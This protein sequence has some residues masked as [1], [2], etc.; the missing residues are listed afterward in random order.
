M[1]NYKN[2]KIF[3]KIEVGN[4]VTLLLLSQ[5]KNA[6]SDGIFSYLKRVKTYLR[7]TMGSN[8]LNVLMLVNVH[9]KILDNK[10]LADVANEFVD[11]KD[12]RK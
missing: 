5:A 6:D 1:R 12:S 9:K 10:N 2:Y 4:I 7:S 11:R 8:R 3:H